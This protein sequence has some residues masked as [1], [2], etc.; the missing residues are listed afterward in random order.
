MNLLKICRKPYVSLLMAFTILFVSC[1]ND[2]TTNSF[3]QNNIKNSVVQHSYSQRDSSER[4]LTDEQVEE[5][6]NIHNEYLNEMI[7]NIDFNNLKNVDISE[8]SK[9]LCINVNCGL[10]IEDKTYIANTFENK[11]L[12]DIEHNLSRD[13]YNFAV[14]VKSNI[15]ESENHNELISNL[16][17]V[18]INA[19][20]I[21]RGAELD[22][23]LVMISVAKSSSYFW[24]PISKGGSGIGDSYNDNLPIYANK[25]R[26]VS[27]DIL[28]ADCIAA[29]EGMS[30]W[31][32]G[33]LLLTGPQSVLAYVISVGLGSA[34]GSLKFYLTEF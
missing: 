19:R 30:L 3:E 33:G 17:A 8:Y 18:E 28:M 9:D 32:L 21:L 26:Y 15:Y 16:Q 6:G 29:L 11:S 24:K 34:Y 25:P 1:N 20:Q 7:S 14:E 5:I 31:A 23:I 12:E 22:Q 2:E 27:D 10:I 4:L 13:V